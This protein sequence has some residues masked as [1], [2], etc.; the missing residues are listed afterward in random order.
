MEKQVRI[1]GIAEGHLDD[2][3]AAWT[4]GVKP[5]RE[6]LGFRHVGAW[7]IEATSEFVWVLGYDGPGD[8]ATADAAYYA[9]DERHAID[10]DPAQWIESVREHPAQGVV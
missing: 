4:A 3:V 10:P 7:S 5:L 1:Y 2:F 8:F 9:S 6:R